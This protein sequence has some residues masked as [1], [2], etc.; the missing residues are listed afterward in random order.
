[1]ALT[2]A[3]ASPDRGE[4]SSP[5]GDP[6]VS[7]DVSGPAI[8]VRGLRKS[9]GKLEAVRGIDLTVETGEVFAFL[10]P[11]GAGKTTTVEILEG[12]RERDAGEVVVLG[13]DPSQP[14]LAWRSRVG[15]VL[16]S[17]DVQRELTARELVRLF[18]GYYEAPLD[19][20]HVLDVVGLTEAGD[21]RARRLSGGQR[22]RLDVALAL[23]G[24]PDLLFLDEPTTGFDPAARR[25]AWAM[26][27]GLKELGKTVFLTTHYLDEA[28]SLADRVAIIQGGRIVAEG[29][30]AE[31]GGD[32]L[33]ITTIRFGLSPGATLPEAL[34]PRAVVDAE[35]FHTI[36]T[37]TPVADLALLCG[38]AQ[39][40]GVEL[41]G[42]EARRP[43]LEDIYLELTG[44][45]VTT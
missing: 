14:D 1:M 24:N 33:Q 37:R 17:G 30:P 43:T 25:E 3:V 28:Q 26:I 20:E 8:F 4:R 16:Q 29:P 22:R 41:V 42:I 38:W 7:A 6:L 35:G 12:Y 15:V 31:I 27:E 5:R 39:Q 9:Y 40:A 11:N 32:A 45:V 23:V 36:G 2:E 44:E 21:R 19:V 10:G 34:G 13:T 18:A